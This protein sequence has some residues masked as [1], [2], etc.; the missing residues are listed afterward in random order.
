MYHIM[1]ENDASLTQ[2]I[3]LKHVKTNKQDGHF[4]PINE[5]PF[6]PNCS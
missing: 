5:H 4:F 2:V 3:D 1:K 6:H